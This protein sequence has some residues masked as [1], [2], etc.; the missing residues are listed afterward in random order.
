MKTHRFKVFGH[1]YEA[2]VVR[3]ED[4]LMVITVNGQEYEVELQPTKRSQIVKPTAKVVRP[5][6]A[7]GEATKVTAKP[8]EAKGAGVV[9]APMPGLIVKVNVRPGDAVKSGQTVIIM[10]AMKMQNNIQASVDG[11]VSKIMVTEGDSVIESQELMI[12]NGS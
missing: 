10:E 2:K 3:R 9:K 8:T 1:E 12:V 11:T 6:A 7:P 4:N 5:S